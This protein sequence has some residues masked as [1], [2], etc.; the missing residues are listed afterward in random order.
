MI[1]KSCVWCLDGWP[2]FF[3]K[4]GEYY[5]YVQTKGH[6]PYLREE[7]CTRSYPPY[8]AKQP[9]P[10]TPSE[11]GSLRQDAI[12]TAALVK[13]AISQ[14]KRQQHPLKEITN[15]QAERAFN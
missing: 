6:K 10:L 8:T 3:D 7:R 14:R 2:A 11:I 9:R 1:M 15:A 13:S 4:K 12:S 5:H